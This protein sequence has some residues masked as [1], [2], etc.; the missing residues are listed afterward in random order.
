[1]PDWERTPGYMPYRGPR[2]RDHAGDSLLLMEI[3]KEGL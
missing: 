2:I 3:N 1:M